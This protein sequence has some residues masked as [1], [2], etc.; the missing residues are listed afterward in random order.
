MINLGK[1]WNSIDH[2]CYT[3]NLFSPDGDTPV[4]TVEPQAPEDDPVY[5]GYYN[6]TPENA[7]SSPEVAYPILRGA[8]QTKLAP[9]PKMLTPSSTDEYV[10]FYNLVCNLT[11]H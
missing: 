2:K 9:F 7:L 6:G 4:I 3:S 10:R 5:G 1:N 11:H 8:I